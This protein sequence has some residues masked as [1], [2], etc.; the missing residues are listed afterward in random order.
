M[1]TNRQSLSGGSEVRTVSTITGTV[2]LDRRWSRNDLR[3]NY[4]T[5]GT[6][7]TGSG[8]NDQFSQFHQFG[9]S[10]VI[11][12]HRWSLMLSD[13]FGYA[14]ESNF[15]NPVING[16]IA[17]VSE[18]G[19]NYT[20]G[21][22]PSYLPNQ[23]VLTGPSARI[24]N[25]IA[26]QVQY[27]TTPRKSITFSASYGILH[28]VDGG[29][30]DSNQITFG[31]GYNFSLTPHNTVAVSYQYGQFRFGDGGSDLSTHSVQ[32]SFGRRLTGRLAFQASGGPQ[33]SVSNNAIGPSTSSVSWTGQNLLLY[34][35][36]KNQVSLGYVVGVTG[37][38]GVFR[39]SRTHSLQGALTRP[40]T[41][42][43]QASFNAGFAHNTALG[44]D[45][46]VNSAYYGLE[47]RRSLWRSAGFFF[48]YNAQR[49][50]TA[51][52][53]CPGCNDSGLRHVIGFGVDWHFRPIRID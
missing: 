50:T 11:T 13:A 34:R 14:P 31:T 53:I 27:R 32:A 51:P 22:N 2:G 23:T 17:S 43:W 36:A 12:G 40:L 49:Q 4:G 19:A 3:L 9:V 24:D 8:I 45:E 1:D 18:A 5:T 16:G 35:R 33:I 20:G 48:N 15:G 44:L 26:G 39:G 30:L 29:F 6:F 52:G 42:R 10:D 7:H 25:T 47:V 38:S 21:L 28:F 46:S 41:R 37:G